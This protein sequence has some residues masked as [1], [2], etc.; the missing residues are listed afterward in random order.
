MSSRSEFWIGIDLGT[1]N[2]SAAIK[3]R[4]G[5][6]DIIKSIGS[7]SKSNLPFMSKQESYKEF[8]SFLSFDKDGS[9]NG[10]GMDS[11]EKMDT[12]S[13]FVVWGIKRLLGK[14][15]KEL[16]D[17]GELDRFPFRIRPDKK[18]GQCLVVIGDKSYTP[19]QL[20]SE[21]FKKIKSDAETQIKENLDSVV[22]SVPA[23][24]DPLRVTP[25]VEAARLAGFIHVKTIPEPVAAAL[26]YHVD[27][28]V[29]PTKVIVFD[30]GAGTLDVTAGYLYRHPDQKDE[31]MFEVMKNTGDPRLGGIDMD[32]RLMK[33]IQK[34]YQLSGDTPSDKAAL[35]R[36]A[37]I[38]K[39]QLSEEPKIEHVFQFAGKEQRCTLNQ[40]D[41]KAALEGGNTQITDKN[42][43]EESRRQIMSAIEESGWSPQDIEL[44]LMIGGPTKLPCFHEVLKII[45]HSNPAI[46]QQ[47]EEF[48]SG[49]ETVD[50]MTAVSIGAALSVDRRVDDRVPHGHGI[51]DLEISEEQMIFSPNILVPRD[52][53]YPFKSKRYMIQWINLHGLFEFKIIQHVPKSEIQQFGYEYR[54]MGIQKFAVKNP[55]MCMVAFQMGY[56]ANKELEVNITNALNP[57]ESTNYVGVNQSTC[58]GM[59]YPLSVKRPP[60]MDKSKVKKV[61]PSAETIEKFIKWVQTTTGFVQRKVDNYPI[62]QMM[63]TQ[64]LDE[65]NMLL[66]KGNPKSEYEGIYTKLNS[67]IWNSNSRGLLTQNEYIELTNHLSEF[68]GELFRLSLK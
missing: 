61:M 49:S 43:L 21:I 26:A 67:L 8:P 63:I 65:I 17:S 10:V 41:L 42:L 14:M 53:A 16:K 2:S 29:K 4:Q 33:V 62:P 34:R 52:S 1:Y 38:V 31:F 3:T 36:I 18:S 51:E 47:L 56:N 12:D 68:E 28:A 66:R 19:V 25:I 57:K 6:I 44:L 48:Y 7:K 13:E 39:I 24:Y 32:D 11:K 46:L 59:N 55:H 64:L 22:V 15:Y 60:D 35:R 23:Y 9:I 5:T 58:I 20:C 40:F 37:E 30:L 50:R 54:F 27:I 45:F